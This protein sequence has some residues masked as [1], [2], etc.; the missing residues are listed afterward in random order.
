MQLRAESNPAFTGAQAV[1][2]SE[3]ALETVRPKADTSLSAK[4]GQQFRVVADA[5]AES[6]FGQMKE[7][8]PASPVAVPGLDDALLN[9]S[10]IDTLKATR[11][12]HA[13]DEVRAAPIEVWEGEVKSVDYDAQMMYVYLRS[14]FTQAPDHSGEIALEWI[15]DQDK[16]L[17]RPGAVF[18]WTL[19]KETRR[20]SIRNSQELRFRRLPSWSKNQL[21]RIEAEASKLFQTPRV[22]R[23]V[24]DS[25]R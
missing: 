1:E 15:T 11:V 24:E 7:L 4:G 13:I 6:S 22:G 25:P 23:V 17:V 21:Q 12:V 8:P 16:D 9:R 2:H 20:G 14:K 18:Y 19:Y 3:V 10:V 5:L